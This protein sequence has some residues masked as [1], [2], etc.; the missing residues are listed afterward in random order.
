ML[1]FIFRISDCKNSVAISFMVVFVFAAAV[2][3]FKCLCAML[4]ILAIVITTAGTVVF[5]GWEIGV[6]EGVI[7]V[8][9]VG[10]SFDYTLHYGA[11]VPT[12]GC[13]AYRIAV[14]VRKAAIPVAM[15][16]LSSLIGGVVMLMA[17]THAFMQV[18]VFLCVSTAWSFLFATFFFLPLLYVFLSLADR[19]TCSA[20]RGIGPRC[21]FCESSQMAQLQ[22]KALRQ[23]FNH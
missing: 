15:S 23:T 19:D 9:V 7:L 14:A 8:L 22:L 11:S 4:T 10:L 1:V 18:A 6:L 2:L 13:S 12:G 3:R 20:T 5:L 21:K 16:A 17:Q